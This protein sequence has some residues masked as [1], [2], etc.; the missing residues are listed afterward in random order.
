MRKIRFAVNHYYH[1]YNRGVDK[2]V[3]FTTKRDYERFLYLLAACNDSGPLLNSQ[4]YYRGFASIVELKKRQPL[5]DIVC[6]CLMPNHYH[7]LLK[8]REENGISRFMQK[9][10]TGYTMYFNTKYDRSG[11]LFQ[12]VFKAIRIDDETY[13]THLTRYI[14]L[15]PA[16]LR[17]SLWKER[18]IRNGK[19]TY[20]FVKRYLWSSYSDYLGENRFP[21]IL[22]KDIM[23]ELYPKPAAY[24]LFIKEWLTKDSDLIS[25]HTLES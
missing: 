14:H 1:V 3:V 9:L 6:F 10:G 12:G 11:S 24:E 21:L 13:L 23:A 20:E 17:E 25:E 4:F 2:R 16:E 7:L 5:V 15:N 22:D 18:G 8:E 19:E